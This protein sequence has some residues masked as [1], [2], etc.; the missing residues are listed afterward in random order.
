MGRNGVLKGVG[1]NWG[2]GLLVGCLWVRG[3]IWGIGVRMRMGRNLGYPGTLG[4][5][6]RWVVLGCPWAWGEFGAIGVL[7]AMGR[8]LGCQGFHGDQERFGIS[9]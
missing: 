3:E 5:R 4:H 8:D 9:G 2:V 6:K 1:K 7:M